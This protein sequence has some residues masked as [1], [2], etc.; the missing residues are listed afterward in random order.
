MKRAFQFLLLIIITGA[1]LND[2]L[3]ERNG[4]GPDVC[5]KDVRRYL[6][7]VGFLPSEVNTI[8]SRARDY[9]KLNEG[10]A[11]KHEALALHMEQMWEKKNPSKPIS[12]GVI[13]HAVRLM[14]PNVCNERVAKYLKSEG[15]HISAVMDICSLADSLMENSSLTKAQAMRKAL[16]EKSV[17]ILEINDEIISEVM[18]LMR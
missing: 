4:K 1:F 13:N 14:S 10:N 7:S 16:F 3:A 15:I 12:Q 9:R 6:K 2:G 17:S 18:R 8:C 11:N 5:N